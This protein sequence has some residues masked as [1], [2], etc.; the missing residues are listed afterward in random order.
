MHWEKNNLHSSYTVM[1]SKLA[2]TTLESNL[3]VPENIS[4]MFDC[5]VF[6]KEKVM[7]KVGIIG[8]RTKN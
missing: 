7:I 5:C 6:C 1:D 4:E 8:K 3:K 2:I